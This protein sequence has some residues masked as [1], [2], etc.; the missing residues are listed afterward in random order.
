MRR[1]LGILVSGLALAV[2]TS[3]PAS[4]IGFG[5]SRMLGSQVQ[6]VN[7]GQPALPPVAHTR[8][9]MDYP[10][11][12]EAKAEPRSLDYPEV[13]GESW[14]TL[15][16]INQ[17]VNRAVQFE[18]NMG[19]LAQE[20]WQ[21]APLTGECHDYAVT[22]RHELV[23]LGWQPRNLLLAEVVTPGGEHHLVLVVR[24]KEGDYVLDN[25]NWSI[26]KVGQTPYRW[27]RIQSPDNPA[28]WSTIERPT[29]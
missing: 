23:A 8:F 28:F 6:R 4:A 27:L 21:I 9:C 22:K 3:C 24:G 1:S 10:A 11:E 20:R 18:R 2:A 15:V 29:V 13:T 14:A 16:Q 25:V 17:Q 12:C 26:R 19:G 5:A 7:F